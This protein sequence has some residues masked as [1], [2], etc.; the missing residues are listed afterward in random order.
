M[1]IYCRKCNISGVGMNEGWYI[2]NQYYSELEMA[3]KVAK[4]CGY[5]S[6]NEMYE[7]E[8]ESYWTEWNCKDELENGQEKFYLED[9]TPILLTKL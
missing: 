2:I 7:I 8:D 3:E 9:G 1:E 5:N 6:W 4:E